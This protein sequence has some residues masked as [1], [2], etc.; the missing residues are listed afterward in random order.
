LEG[1]GGFDHR[2]LAGRDAIAQAVQRSGVAL[3]QV[4]G[5]QDQGG[6]VGGLGRGFAREGGRVLLVAA[7]NGEAV[8]LEGA[9]RGPAAVAAEGEDE[10]DDQA[11]RRGAEHPE[12]E[13]PP[14]GHAAHGRP[15]TWP[16]WVSTWRGPSL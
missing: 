16:R 1:E 9:D 10:G 14:P 7:E 5:G 2:A 8:V 13:H 4:E 11:D 6:V 12:T 15:F 3:H